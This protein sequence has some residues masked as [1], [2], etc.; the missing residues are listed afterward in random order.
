MG[1][2]YGPQQ[3]HD[4]YAA[5][6]YPQQPAYGID[7][8][9]QQGYAPQPYGP[10]YGYAAPAYPPGYGY[11]QPRAGGGTA[12][13]AAVLSLLLSLI[14]LGGM[15]IAIA[16]EMDTAGYRDGSARSG[17]IAGFAIASVP[18]LLW[19]LGS[20]L[21]FRRK[22]AGRVLLIILS[23]LGLLVGAISVAVAADS[24]GGPA[25]IAGLVAAAIPL[26]ILTLAAAPST[27]R[28][29]RAGRQ[30]AYAPYPYY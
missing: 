8:Y 10:E 20:I 28:W 14:A 2:P 27:G 25:L 9:A 15:G 4:P 1:Y 30:P 11:P 23:S 6:G 13:T 16:S 17:T 21:L 24:G 26:L 12:I 19:L 22:T 3:G 18:C 5:Q 29:I 7:P